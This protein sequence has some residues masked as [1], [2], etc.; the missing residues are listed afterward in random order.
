MIVGAFAKAI[1][2]V[3]F[4]F[5][6]EVADAVPSDGSSLLLTFG[7]STNSFG[8]YTGGATGYLTNET[9]CIIPNS[10]NYRSGIDHIL[11]ADKDYVLAIIWDGSQYKFAVTGAP[12]TQITAVAGPCPLIVS[13]KLKYSG[14]YNSLKSRYNM[15]SIQ[16]LSKPF[17]ISA[18]S[19]VDDPYQLAVSI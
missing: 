13:E 17:S 18:P 11:T 8:I 16:V 9:V 3:V 10:G 2:G 15:Y 19:F 14:R 6:L 7:D 4:H 1:Y 5:R 12:F